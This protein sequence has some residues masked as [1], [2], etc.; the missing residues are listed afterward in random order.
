[1]NSSQY[2]YSSPSTFTS[3]YS[4]SNSGGINIWIFLFGVL[5]FVVI[6]ILVYKTYLDKSEVNNSFSKQIS[7]LG[8]SFA[9][10]FGTNGSDKTKKTNLVNETKSVDLVEGTVNKK[11]TENVVGANA[12]TSI[13]G[14][15]QTNSNMNPNQNSNMNY[16]MNPNQNLNSAVNNQRVQRHYDGINADDATSC[17]QNGKSLNKSGW[18]YIGKEQGYRSC[19]DVGENDICMSGDIFPSQEICVNPSLRA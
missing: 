16:N 14:S 17:I 13:K 5:I 6:G 15:Q 18:C 12:Q 1:M 4:S 11:V 2:T 10:L 19:I 7:S 8:N 3:T 9:G